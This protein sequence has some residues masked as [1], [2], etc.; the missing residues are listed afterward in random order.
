MSLKTSP[1]NIDTPNRNVSPGRPR[2]TLRDRYGDRAFNIAATAILLLSI[3]AVVYPLYFIVIASVSDPNAI[4][5]GKVWLFPSGV[6]FEGYQR[7][8]A[9][10]RIWNGL[11]NTVIYT[12]LGTAISVTTILCGAYALSRKDMPGRKILMLLFVI[13]MFF[14]G[15]LIT[16]YLVVRDLGMLNTVWAVVLPGAVGV[17][18]LIIARSFFEH[19]IPNELREAAQMDGATD[20]KFFF[21]MVLPLSK[22][23]IML[24]VM[25]HVVAQ[26]NS[27]F[28]A[29]IF[30]NDDSK[31]PLQLVL[32]NILIQSDVSSTGTT[33]GDIQS[34]AAAQRIAELTKYAMIVVSS[35]PLMIALPF[36]QKHFTK[37]AMIGAVK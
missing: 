5:E 25:I 6:T 30:L 2:P 36:M 16:K 37:G 35:L 1:V 7:I 26:W 17:W 11:G 20:F 21:K 23:L 33:G 29:L 14:D 12:V 9:D 22:P 15:G 28:D 32:R 31:Y 27:F 19:T 8:F 3:L 34:Y 4:Y 13:T 18:N 24:M 10:S